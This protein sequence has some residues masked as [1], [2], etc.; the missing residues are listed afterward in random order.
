MIAGGGRR[1]GFEWVG[2]VSAH[3]NMLFGKRQIVL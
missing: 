1:G 3:D 2:G